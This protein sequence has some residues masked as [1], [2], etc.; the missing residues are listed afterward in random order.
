MPRTPWP[1]RNILKTSEGGMVN[2]PGLPSSPEKERVKK[3][4]PKG[5]G[6]ILGSGSRADL[7]PERN[8]LIR[9]SL[10]RILR[11]WRRENACDSSGYDHAPAAF[12]GGAARDGCNTGFHSSFDRPG[13]YRR[14]PCRYR[15]GPQQSGKIRRETMAK[16]FSD[17]TQTVGNTPACAF[18]P[19]RAG[20]RRQSS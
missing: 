5:A 15:S 9:S 16:I 1:S 14:H 18:E 19:Y 12:P 3:Y 10:F 13:T 11:T 17:I 20:C 4:L 2:Y 8:S 7:K 6:A